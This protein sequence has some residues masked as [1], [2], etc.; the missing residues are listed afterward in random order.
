M[1]QVT[2]M[3]MNLRFGLARDGENGWTH[4]KHLDWIL[5]RGGLVPVFRQVVKYSSLNRFPSDHYPVQARFE[6]SNI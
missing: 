6:W 2:V 1:S 3:T 4:R 5:F